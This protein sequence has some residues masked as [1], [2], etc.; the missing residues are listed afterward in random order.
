MQWIQ[1]WYK[2]QEVYGVKD[3]FR[4]KAYYHRADKGITPSAYGSRNDVAI[5]EKRRVKRSQRKSKHTTNALN[6]MQPFDDNFIDPALLR[7]STT[8]EANG[9]VP[10][11]DAEANTDAHH[12]PVPA[13][14]TRP[15]PA[16]APAPAHQAFAPDDSPTSSTHSTA[17]DPYQPVDPAYLELLKRY[18]HQLP[19]PPY[20]SP[21]DSGSPRFVLQWRDL[22]HIHQ[23]PPQ[24][25][26]AAQA[27]QRPRPT[28]RSALSASR[29]EVA[30]G[31]DVPNSLPAT[32]Q[33]KER[34][35]GR[36]KQSK[37]RKPA[38]VPV[39]SGSRTTRQTHRRVTRS[40]KYK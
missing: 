34:A 31:D 39:G 26:D 38:V 18:G 15:L 9:S 37:K 23:E 29:Q 40:G 24:T 16:P 5:A 6:G 1:H 4:W 17:P 10:S 3:A 2:R 27:R 13:L 36:E 30:S 8:P 19:E 11:A 33:N 32:Q 12:S 7:R 20:G 25:P 21:N 14:S 28:R 35:A 22:E